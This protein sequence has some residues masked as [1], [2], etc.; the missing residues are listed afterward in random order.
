MLAQTWLLDFQPG[1]PNRMER[2]FPRIFFNFPEF[3][4][5]TRNIGHWIDELFFNSI[6]FYNV[7]TLYFFT[8]IK[9]TLR[10]GFFTWFIYFKFRF[11][12]T[13]FSNFWKVGFPIHDDSSSTVLFEL[14]SKFFNFSFHRFPFNKRV[15][16]LISIITMSYFSPN[17]S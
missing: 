9:I 13:F 1:Y 3:L 8:R 5:G 15:K 16:D 14:L 6:S 10:M 4:S 11:I 17:F 12:S 2:R 7:E